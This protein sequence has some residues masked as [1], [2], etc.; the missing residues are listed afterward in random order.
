MRKFDKSVLLCATASLFSLSVVASESIQNIEQEVAVSTGEDISSPVSHENDVEKSETPDGSLDDSAAGIPEISEDIVEEIGGMN[1]GFVEASEASPGSIAVIE[2]ADAEL[3]D[4][5]IGEQIVVEGESNYGEFESANAVDATQVEAEVM[6]EMTEAEPATDAKSA[7]DE[8]TADGGV[9][10]TLEICET[11][12]AASL[13]TNT[14]NTDVVSAPS[15]TRLVA[16][17]DWDRRSADTAGTLQQWTRWWRYLRMQEP[18]LMNWIDGLVIR[19]HPNTEVHRSL[20]VRGIYDPNLIV[21]VNTLLNKGGTLIDAGAGIGHFT[22]LASKAV[23]EHGH[24]YAVEPSSR[25]FN[26]LVDNINL[27]GLQNVICA[28]RCAFSD[29][30]SGNISLSIAHK[31]RNLLSTTGSEFSTKG[32]EKVASEDVSLT[33]I[34]ELVLNNRV[35]RVDVIKLDIE[36]GE[37]RAL[38]GAART[39]AKFRPAIMVGVH[40]ISV[41]ANGASREEIQKFFTNSRYRLYTIVFRPK[42]ELRLVD[43][44]SRDRSKVL[45]AL[46]ESV[47]PPALPQPELRSIVSSIRDFFTQ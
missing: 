5:D 39:I 31:E 35:S 9:H 21:V 16:I 10:E 34:D 29:V 14:E 6:K 13:S 15:Y 7:L 33:T 46:H 40:P 17:R 26:K 47:V 38:N 23:G 19:I 25:E 27:N 41:K 32:I 43:D 4:N 22:L 1:K 8:A 36:G 28:S 18:A 45:F 37:L 11:A 44:L 12:A 20:F 30:S 24:I 42:F 2:S 3:A